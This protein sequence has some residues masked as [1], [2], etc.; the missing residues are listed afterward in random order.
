MSFPIGKWF[1]YLSFRIQGYCTVRTAHYALL[2]W[3]SLVTLF[4]LFKLLYTAQQ[5]ACMPLYI[6]REGWNAIVMG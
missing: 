5:L 1:L 2:T 6:V 4:I 3:F